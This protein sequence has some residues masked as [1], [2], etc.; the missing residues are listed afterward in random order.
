MYSPHSEWG[1]FV[2]ACRDEE[3]LYIKF[4]P[5]RRNAIKDERA[6]TDFKAE[7]KK[8]LEARVERFVANLAF[9]TEQ[10]D[11]LKA[12]LTT[13]NGEPTRDE[14]RL[15]SERNAKFK[16]DRLAWT[17]RLLL[18]QCDFAENPDLYVKYKDVRIACETKERENTSAL[19]R[20]VMKISACEINIRLRDKY[21]ACDIDI[22]LPG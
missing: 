12:Q 19:T 16:K 9:E 10:G 15:F 5:E 11:I 6:D 3:S 7:T 4:N 22:Q 20:C 13:L 8:Y 17:T 1:D 14:I 2:K 18:S 21:P